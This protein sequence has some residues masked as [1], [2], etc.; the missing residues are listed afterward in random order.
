MNRSDNVEL[1]EMILSMT[2]DERRELGIN[3]ST[4]WHIKKSLSEGKTPKIYEKILLNHYFEFKW[5]MNDITPKQKIL[6]NRL[7]QYDDNIK[8]A[9]LGSIHILNSK[10]YPERLLE[11]GQIV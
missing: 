11:C 10:E 3:K 7:K 4:L 6:S 1:R 8:T 2:D 5:W 9:Y